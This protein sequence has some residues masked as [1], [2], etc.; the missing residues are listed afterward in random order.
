M[1]R[2]KDFYS[3]DML[4]IGAAW[5]CTIPFTAAL[6]VPVY[7]AF[8]FLFTSLVLF[9]IAALICWIMCGWKLVKKN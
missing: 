5:L 9:V 3:E 6:I 4:W 2:W 7:G 8:A 1:F